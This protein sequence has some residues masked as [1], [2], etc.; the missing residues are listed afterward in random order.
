MLSTVSIFFNKWITVFK[1]YWEC[2]NHYNWQSYNCYLFSCNFKVS[3]LS[4]IVPPSICFQCYSNRHIT[5]VK[6]VFS[7]YNI[8]LIKCY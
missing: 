1:K 4:N 2:E 6:C 3:G 8:D 5:S 7:V